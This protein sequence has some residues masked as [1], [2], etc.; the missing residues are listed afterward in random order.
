MKSECVS[1]VRAFSAIVVVF[2]HCY[3][4][5]F[6]K[7]VFG[8]ADD[9]N[10]WYVAI[11]CGLITVAMPMFFFLSGY[12]FTWSAVKK[13]HYTSFAELMRKKS[14][15]LVLPYFVWSVVMMLA[16]GGPIRFGD[17]VRGN[18]DHLWFLPS[19]LWCFVFGYVLL[20]RATNVYIWLF[21]LLLAFAL[22]MSGIVLPRVFGLSAASRYLCWFVA[23]Q[24]F[25]LH[26]D[27]FSALLRD[28]LPVL[29]LMMAAWVVMLVVAPVAYG[30][31]QTVWSLLSVSAV[32]VS[33]VFLA[34]RTPALMADWGGVIGRLSFGIYLLHFMLLILF[35]QHLG[36]V[37]DWVASSPAVLV[38][39]LSVVIL[40]VSML[41]TK[42]LSMT[43][44]GRMLV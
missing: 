13:G 23:G 41:L 18:N 29:L 34:D 32:L 25:C 33:S 3:A 27:R 16:T 24:L 37:A 15:R 12:C 38:L 17:L 40:A 30:A 19:L 8:P 2:F 21:C 1:V 28:R 22:T 4:M 7:G 39:L 5:F 42:L 11:R 9:G 31:T 44:I 14:L 36:G 6:D 10:P 26:Y 20:R 35:L 43:R